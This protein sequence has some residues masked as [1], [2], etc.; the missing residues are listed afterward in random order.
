MILVAR[1]ALKYVVI[2]SLGV[3]L[4][5]DEGKSVFSQTGKRP[6][7]SRPQTTT[8]KDSLAEMEKL[9]SEA[10]QHRK[11]VKDAEDA[12]RQIYVAGASA[13]GP[14]RNDL[15]I[16]L[17]ALTNMARRSK[18]LELNCLG[19]AEEMGKR[20]LRQAGPN[21]AK[22]REQING[23]YTNQ[24]YDM[25]D[26]NIWDETKIPESILSGMSEAEIVK[27]RLGF[28]GMTNPDVGERYSTSEFGIFLPNIPKTP[29]SKSNS[30]GF[31]KEVVAVSKKWQNINEFGL[32]VRVE[33]TEKGPLEAI[34]R[35][36][37]SNAT[38]MAFSGRLISK[39][40]IVNIKL[41]DGTPAM[42]LTFHKTSI[43]SSSQTVVQF[44][45]IVKGKDLS[46]WHIRG[47]IEDSKYAHPNSFM[48]E[49]LKQH[50]LTFCFDSS[51]L[52]DSGLRRTYG[53]LTAQGQSKVQSAPQGTFQ[54]RGNPANTEASIR[55]IVTQFYDA[56]KRKDLS[57]LIAV[58]STQSPY[59]VSLRQEAEKSFAQA[60][61]KRYVD[62]SLAVSRIVINGD[63]AAARVTLNIPPCDQSTKLRLPGRTVQNFYFIKE[64]LG[65]TI[66]QSRPAAIDLLDK[67][68]ELPVWYSEDQKDG[69]ILNAR[70]VA[71]LSEDR[72]AAIE[73]VDFLID[74]GIGA[75]QRRYYPESLRQFFLAFRIAEQVDHQ[76]G[77]SKVKLNIGNLYY[78][79]GNLEQAKLYYQSIR[80]H[81]GPGRETL[82]IPALIGLGNVAF[83]QGNELEAKSYFEDSLK[84][85]DNSKICT[86][87][88]DWYPNL[89]RARLENNLGIT[90]F[91]LKNTVEGLKH[92]E[93]SKNSYE[94]SGL[95]KDS[96]EIMRA[97][98]KVQY[99]IA[100]H[101]YLFD[102]KRVDEALQYLS[103]SLQTFTK[104]D[105]LPEVALCKSILGMAL[106]V[107]GD[108]QKAFEYAK[109][110][111][112]L[113][114]R[115]D[116]PNT[117]RQA[118]VALGLF[119]QESIKGEEALKAGRWDDVLKSGSWNNALKEYNSA[120]DITE[121]M[122]SELSSNTTND[123]EV[124]TFLSDKILPW[125]LKT[126]LLITQ[127]QMY[128]KSDP[129]IAQSKFQEAFKCAES[130]KSRTL[131]E[132]LQKHQL[133]NEI[134]GYSSLQDTV[135]LLPD[136][137]TALLEYVV[138]GDRT[139]LF[140]LTR[141]KNTGKAQVANASTIEISRVKLMKR[142]YDFKRLISSEEKESILKVEALN[143]YRL[144]LSGGVT[145][146][147]WTK[148]IIIPDGP[149]W[150]LPFQALLTP[151]GQYF[152]QERVISYSPSVSV[153]KLLAHRRTRR[154]WPIKSLTLFAVGDPIINPVEKDGK[155]LDDI[156]QF[157]ELA[158]KLVRF[159]NVNP[160]SSALCV[161]DCAEEMVRKN[162]GKYDV[163]FLGA[164]GKTKYSDPM[165]S[166]L[167]LARSKTV[168]QDDGY[169]HAWEISQSDMSR[170]ELAFLGAC[171]GAEGNPIDGEGM[172]G[173]SWSFLAAGCSTVVAA[174]W[175][176]KPV[177]TSDLILSFHQHLKASLTGYDSKRVQTRITRAEALQK[178]IL[179]Q[180]NSNGRHKHPKHWAPF[181]LIGDWQ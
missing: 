176:V 58:I 112:N 38:E 123:L 115:T 101:L 88:P 60:M 52:D 167:V 169:W 78:I 54:E 154:V 67:L 31:F 90:Y 121:S 4:L 42:L 11:A 163:L 33:Y 116:D 85:L 129:L 24:S 153:L 50:I 102:P 166:Y 26:P 66:F 80:K 147:L 139:F 35:S 111:L 59:R 82:E 97:M 108:R 71:S 53:R 40:T 32:R 179:N 130:A 16:Q 165:D 20:M 156:S 83:K 113:A 39:E 168:N 135:D 134:P 137:Q 21:Q 1:T 69:V 150:D 140:I 92:L 15:A 62:F 107:K 75:A 74:V 95:S 30:P 5:A 133:T 124:Q 128:Q 170:L 162:A 144:L 175:E 106:L 98:A 8:V 47:E 159:Y 99:N 180:L 114:I 152:I 46:T 141:D 48:A 146:S 161:G 34:A 29:V 138:T 125:H 136:N 127:G 41:S 145:T 13:T 68:R 157:Q 122:R 49:I 181:I 158:Q 43:V 2:I 155:P 96:R 28:L 160:S 164:H 177:F 172:V 23:L 126:D 25:K 79:Q 110:G 6:V 12:S 148:L 45:L 3:L 9:L 10:A 56:Y 18:A 61:G 77:V 22:L 149:L 70:A 64:P 51:A 142:V 14:Q 81:G 44:E 93:K 119:Y 73:L 94:N 36:V 104:L 173:L 174:Q 131:L 151:Q 86:S 143:L 109:D 84:M 37:I 72:G 89:W 178:A 7:P 105:L 27:E 117:I 118:H 132:M 100:S 57:G 63:Q 87:D 171:S 120:I 91:A 19:R 17:N 76:D 103:I 65:W 55:R